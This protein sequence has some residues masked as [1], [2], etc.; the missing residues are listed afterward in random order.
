MRLY[1]Y[2]CLCILLVLVSCNSRK[3]SQQVQAAGNELYADGISITKHDGYTLVCIYNPWEKDAV[4]HTY[5]L[6]PREN[7][8]PEN[9]PQGSI[10]RTPIKSALVYSSVHANAIKELGHLPSVTGVC[11]AQ[12]FTMDEIS[13]GIQSGAITN[14]GSSMSPVIEKIIALSPEVI[15]LSPFQNAGYGDVASL[16]IPIVECADYMETSPLGRAEWIKL[17]GALYCEEE[18]ADSI[19]ARVTTEYNQLKQLAEK[20]PHKPK[21]L[22]ENIING[23]WYVPGGDSYMAKLFADAGGRYAWSDIRTSGSIPLDMPRVLEKAIDAD[24][25]LIKSFDETFSYSK[26]KAQ[27]SMNA[28]FKAFK[29]KNI[30]F[31]NTGKSTFFQ[32]FPFHPE[33]LLKEYISIF[34]PHFISGYTPKYF[35]PLIH[36]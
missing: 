35:K 30:Y 29:E 14:A 7:E 28:E 10:I 19:F 8:L 23:T 18:C 21:I 1:T 12:Y 2:F 5:V 32:D 25:W 24:I 6:I 27:N 17:F 31:C 20:V 16:N 13:E 3:E 4:L 36:E 22:S 33:V 11:D 26:L 34:H 9:L 15:I